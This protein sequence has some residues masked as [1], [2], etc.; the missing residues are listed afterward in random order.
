MAITESNIYALWVARQT[1]GKGTAA[2]TATKRLIHVAGDLDLN[3][4]DGSENYSDLDRFG[5]AT[6]YISSVS[7]QGTPG[8]QAQPNSVAYLCWLFFGGA[9]FTAKVTGTS[10]PRYVFTPGAN[11]GYWSTWWKRVGQ[12]EVVRQKFNDTKI[13]AL[14]LE[15]GT[16]QRVLRVTPTLTSLDP[17]EVFST[18]PTPSLSSITPL[19]WTDCTGTIKLD[20]VA[21]AFTGTTQV[22][23]T[24][25][26]GSQPV[27]G[28]GTR[29][30][31]LV[32]GNASIT[33]EGPTIVLDD[34][35]RARYNNIIYGKTS[36]TAGDKPITTKPVIGSFEVEWARGTGDARES[37]KVALPGVKWTPDLA[38][39]PNPDGG[40]IEL[41][42]N[43]QMRKV[44]GSEA[45]TITV[46]TG[47][48]DNAAYTS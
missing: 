14:K 26:D 24:I 10:A 39:A 8:I 32:P 46:E 30:Y 21:T 20:G 45:I 28:D 19:L 23:I 37:V 15:G 35:S 33:M 34:A 6:D 25:D 7:G 2:T 40:P 43:G 12:S 38:I 31:D 9:T 13:T 5:Q 18:D 22:S 16:Q 48:G 1:S 36:P 29:Y 17:G 41:A 27:Q 47:A 4:E 11:T 44:S 42:L 3:R